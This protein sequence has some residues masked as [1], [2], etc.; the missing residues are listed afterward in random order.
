MVR[1]VVKLCIEKDDVMQWHTQDVNITTN[2]KVK[3]YFTLPA[4][5]DTNVV[6]CKCHVDDSAKG[7]YGIILRRYILI[8]LGLNL[9]FSEHVIKADD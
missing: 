3:L 8:E 4:F 6:T 5:S 9:E 2:L 1:L 7:G